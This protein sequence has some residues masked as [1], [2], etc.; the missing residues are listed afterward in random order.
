MKL[1]GECIRSHIAQ[2]SHGIE[3]IEN[4]ESSS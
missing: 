4:K 3:I 1:P 2:I